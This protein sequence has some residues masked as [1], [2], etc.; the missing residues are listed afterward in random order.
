MKLAAHAR[1]SRESE[2]GEHRAAEGP[3]TSVHESDCQHASPQNGSHGRVL[4]IRPIVNDYR[5]P[6][7]S[8][9]L[10]ARSR[11]VAGELFLPCRLFSTLFAEGQA[12]RMATIVEDMYSS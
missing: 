9:G 12:F 2:P 10:S 11:G 6:N 7:L 5:D 3:A 4:G 1:R 8:Q